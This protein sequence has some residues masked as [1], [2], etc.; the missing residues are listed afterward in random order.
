MKARK[1]TESSAL[2]DVCSSTVSQT[3]ASAGEPD[4]CL[5]GSPGGARDERGDRLERDRAVALEPELAELGDDD[6][7]VLAGDVAEDE[8]C[9]Q[10]C[11]HPG[12]RTTLTADEMIE[13]S[14]GA[15]R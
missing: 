8:I 3:T 15:S 14:V 7:G 13:Q 2:S 11:R 4:G 9:R 10:A 6:A 5:L 12:M 1:L